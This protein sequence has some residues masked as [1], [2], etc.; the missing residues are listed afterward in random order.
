MTTGAPAATPGTLAT[1]AYDFTSAP[2]PRHSLAVSLRSLSRPTT[3]FCWCWSNSSI[4]SQRA[5]SPNFT[6]SQILFSSVAH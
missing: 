1:S 2:S 3:H 5:A 6:S 4:L